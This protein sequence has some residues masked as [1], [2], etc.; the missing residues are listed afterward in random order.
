MEDIE[1]LVYTAATRAEH[2][3]SLS[4]SDVSISE[5]SLDVLPNIGSESGEYTEKHVIETLSLTETLESDLSS[6]AS[7]PFI[8]E[9]ETFL[10][11]RIE[12]NFRMNVS[13]LQNFL[14]ITS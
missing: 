6:L 5:K 9:E 8:S 13:A 2:F 4:Y 10:R 12:K 14:D 3:L 11:E 1:R 7:L